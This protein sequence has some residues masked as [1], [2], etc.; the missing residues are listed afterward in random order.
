M[1]DYKTPGVYVEEISTLPPSVGQVPTAVPAFIGYTEKASRN[2]KSLRNSP[3]HITSLL[4][5]HEMFGGNSG[6]GKVSVKLN[7]DNSVKAVSFEKN[8]YLYNSIR[9]FFAN[10]GGE[11]YIVSVGDYGD[12]VSFDALST[13]L[14]ALEKEDHPTILVCPDAMLIEK[15][16]QAYSLQQAMLAQC[17]KLQDRVAVLDV[18][19]GNVAREDD[20]VVL[21][22]RNGI[23]I[24]HLKYGAAYYPWIQTT[25]STDFGFEDVALMDASDESVNIADL[26]DDPTAINNVLSAISDISQLKAFA[27]N[28]LGS[29][30]Q[31]LKD[32]FYGLAE[33]QE[34]TND[35]LGHYATILKQIIDKILDLPNASLKNELIVN[36]LKIKLNSSSALANV[37]RSLGAVDS[38]L[39]LGIVNI[40]SDYA[41]YGLTSAN[42]YEGLEEGSKFKKGKS[43]LENLFN[44]LVGVLLSIKNDSISIKE[45]LDKVVYDTNALYNNIVN[46]IQK[47]GSML[48]PSG[49]VAGVYAQVDA[50]R[51]VWKAPA[52]VSLSSTASPWVK[53]DNQ[54]QED[55]N[56]DVM[57]GKSVNAIRNFTGKGTLVW[58]ARTLAGNDN[59][60]R[61]ISVRRFFN[62]VEKSVQLSTN[63]AV[64]EPNDV[65]TWVR[66]KAMIENYLTNLWK[67]G[68]LAGATPD[69]AFFVNIGLGSTMS[70]VDILEGRMNVEI[71]MAAVRPAEFIILKFSHKLQE[72]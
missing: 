67:A 47:T 49:S 13:G 59:E 48:P 32:S 18:Y 60:W 30:D 9:M 64:F 20:D 8:Y 40:E 7:K 70:A 45:S 50:N 14:S 11:C 22:F 52:N 55:L 34:G 36:E 27:K 68:A 24:N 71:G 58:G 26:V 53:I 57:A 19:N 12:D 33:G 21:D 25:L 16:D 69:A 43:A 72:S 6:H 63:W 31:S 44:E 15:K 28:P 39:D 51:G 41:M 4:D 5:Y 65:T 2:G 61:Y 56:V 46:E 17:N 54:Q 1:A 66:V 3:K 42:L 62:M 35:E 10:G 38:S 37:V 23:G 29:E